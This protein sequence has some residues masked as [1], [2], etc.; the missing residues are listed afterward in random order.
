MVYVLMGGPGSMVSLASF[1]SDGLPVGTAVRDMG[2]QRG[3][4]AGLGAGSSGE[5][6]NIAVGY[7]VVEMGEG[8][9]Y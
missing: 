6:Y 1:G 8:K 7:G 2:L 4:L 9:S 3:S 5:T